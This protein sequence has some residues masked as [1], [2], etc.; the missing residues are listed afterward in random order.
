MAEDCLFCGI[1]AGAVPSSKVREDDAT[2]AFTDINPQA[3]LHVLVVPK[4][5]LAN[6][7]ELGADPETG[8]ALLA[9]IRAIAQEQA[10]T[11]FRTVLNTGPMVGQSVFHVH[12]H[13][14]AGRPMT[15]PPG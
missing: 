5:H 6:V 9:A 14:L 10:L 12:A 11:D 2:L 4:K 7:I 8:A 1:V 3:P 15:W 13:V